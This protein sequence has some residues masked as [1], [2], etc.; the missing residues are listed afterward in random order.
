MKLTKFHKACCQVSC[1]LNMSDD[2]QIVMVL[3]Y[4]SY[5]GHDVMGMLC[6]HLKLGPSINCSGLT[7]QEH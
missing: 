1:S 3:L 6:D 7:G 4:H 2:W 5:F